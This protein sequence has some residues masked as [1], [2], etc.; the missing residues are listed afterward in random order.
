MRYK[1]SEI[2]GAF[3]SNAATPLDAWHLSE[4][5]SSRPTLGATFIQDATPTSRVVA[6][7]AE[8]E[9]IMDI[10]HG[11]TCVRPMPMYGIPA[12]LSRF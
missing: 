6:T 5:H 8:P 9:I 4:E 1:P 7:P 3:R 2:H 10:L 11:L 12:T